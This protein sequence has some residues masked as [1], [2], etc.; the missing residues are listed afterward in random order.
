MLLHLL[1]HRNGII[2]GL[3]TIES[4]PVPFFADVLKQVQFYFV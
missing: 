4:N 3:A 1:V 2:Q